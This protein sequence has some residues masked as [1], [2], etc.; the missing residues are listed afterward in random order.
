MSGIKTVTHHLLVAALTCLVVLGVP[1]GHAEPQP[2]LTGFDMGNSAQMAASASVEAVPSTQGTTGQTRAMAMMG[3]DPLPPVPDET[4]EKFSTA[5]A[6]ASFVC[7]ILKK[8]KSLKCFGQNDVGQSSPPKGQFKQLSLGSTHGCATTLQNKLLC[9]GRSDAR[10]Q[11]GQATGRYLSVAA[12]DDHTC[13]RTV[14]N[15]VQCWGN[16][17]NG[18]LNVPP[19]KY[20]QLDARGDHTCAITDARQLTCW[21]DRAFTAFPQTQVGPFVKV[22]TGQL[23]GCVLG[24]NGLTKCWG[25]DAYG[26]IQAPQEPFVDI[27]AGDW[28]TC[29]LRADH[30][31]ICWGR[32]Q[33]GQNDP[34]QYRYQQISA[35]GNLTCG[36]L[37]VTGHMRCVG[38]FASNALFYPGSENAN[39]A[40]Q[41]ADSV[42]PQ[43]AFLAVFE[44]VSALLASGIVNTGKAI[45]K[46]GWSWEKGGIM[47]QLGALFTN[48]I[49]GWNKK[50]APDKYLP[51]LQKIQAD[52]QEIKIDVGQIQGKLDSVLI[53][54]DGKWCDD[55]LAPYAAAYNLMSGS[56]Y[57]D[58]TGARKA[59]QDLLSA[60]ATQITSALNNTPA[61]YPTAEFTKFRDHYLGKLKSA[62]DNL[63]NSLLGAAG[64]ASSLLTCLN[65]GHTEWKA[66]VTPK[67]TRPELAF[68]DR[69]IYKYAYDVLR[70]A[71]ILQGEMLLMI[72]DIETRGIFDTL[73]TT[74]GQSSAVVEVDPTTF[75]PTESTQGTGFC[76]YVDQQ[77]ALKPADPGYNP[78]W[79]TAAT[80][81]R[82]NRTLIN[83]TYVAMVKQVEVLGGAYSDDQM[84]LSLT[85][86]QMGLADKGESNWLWSRMPQIQK[87]PLGW[88]FIG[89]WDN[90]AANEL[91]A[92]IVWQR[93]IP[94]GP[95]FGLLS[96]AGPRN[97]PWAPGD[98]I[99]Y[100]QNAGKFG[101][102]VWHSSGKA[103]DDIYKT[104]EA[105]RVN[106][107]GTDEKELLKNKED[108]LQQM[109][110][111]PD[112]SAASKKLFVGV[113]DVPFAMP[114]NYAMLEYYS[115][116]KGGSG[117]YFGGGFNCFVAS[118]INTDWYYKDFGKYN[119]AYLSL[120]G[121]VCSTE[122]MAA[123][124]VSDEGLGNMKIRGKSC[125]KGYC[126]GIGGVDRF[127]PE[128]Y[129]PFQQM[130]GNYLAWTSLTT[131]WTYDWFDIYDQFI[132]S[133]EGGSL[134]HMPVVNI[135]Q[136][137]CK[138][139]MVKQGVAQNADGTRLAT[140]SDG[141]PSI[142]GED[143][144]KTISKLIPRPQYP[145]NNPELDA[146]VRRPEVRPEVQ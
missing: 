78:R 106:A 119:K 29:G 6:G 110:N 125:G 115:K 91:K 3:D 52:V 94:Q 131:N 81:C 10:P 47:V 49:L 30:T 56:P 8:D 146:M 61:A 73:Q 127:T 122:E 55:S 130:L 15:E 22:A 136:R 128:R 26:Q 109:A 143:L 37:R 58:S 43:L 121:K 79:T 33:Y 17:Q 107:Y 90:Y 103:W 102:G 144:D 98:L 57:G 142:C 46:Q 13:A 60:Q 2:I 132:P 24:Q 100:E 54:L 135:T 66:K 38:S 23:H 137:I 67:G 105:Q 19:G 141:I 112:S 62:K 18:E 75:V 70:N 32:Y 42:R 101:A 83:D 140:R 120:T 51:T 118:G 72:E 14:K 97:E 40:G 133:V 44:G 35:G 95:C 68:D 11:P 93:P 9:W 28:H 126:F 74:T 76:W 45:D 108:L 114:G 7:G 80:G 116:G 82:H 145:E 139:P 65:K 34:G 16:N 111:T 63:S 89:P 64:Q 36:L 31:G 86:K 129:K 4:K 117:P 92:P 77:A 71:L 21:G 1:N 87:N 96:C 5:D 113:T 39:T 104:R 20:R 124:L 12:G 53:K 27:V 123:M 84:V 99:I 41:S 50:A 59:Y 85:A 134:N 69:P 88:G 138:T 25:N 48:M